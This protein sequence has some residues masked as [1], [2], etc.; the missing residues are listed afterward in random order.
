MRGGFVEL[1][2]ASACLG[3]ILGAVLSYAVGL[4]DNSPW[5]LIPLFLVAWGPLVVLFA[6]ALQLLA[7]I[8]NIASKLLKIFDD[9]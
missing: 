7:F 1:A 2:I 8:G 3:A 6:L 9:D 5:L 4:P